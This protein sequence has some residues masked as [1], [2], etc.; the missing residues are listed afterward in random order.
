MEF[1]EKI[2]KKYLYVFDS[3]NLFENKGIKIQFPDDDDFQL[4]LFRIEGNLYCLENI[5]PHRHADRIFEG[6]IKD[7]TVTCPLHGWTYSIRT[8]ENMNKRQGLKNLV[9]YECFELNGKIY[10]EE[11]SFKIPKWRRNED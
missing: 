10:V 3:K 5:C 8:G 9:H 11:P 6:I 2:G 7:M 1:I 4:A